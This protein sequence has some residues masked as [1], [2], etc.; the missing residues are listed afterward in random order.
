MNNI[1]KA[2]FLIALT[3]ASSA[4][5]ERTQ[6]INGGNTGTTSATVIIPPNDGTAHITDLVWDLDNTVTT[7]TI[8]IRPGKD[9]FSVTSATSGTGSVIWFDNSASSAAAASYLILETSTSTSLVRCT[10]VATTSVTVQETVAAMAVGNKVWTTRGTFRRNAPDQT[11]SSTLAP[12]NLYLPAKVPS[13]ITID[14]NTTA[15]KIYVG[16]ERSRD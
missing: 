3:F 4:F 9:E 5:A 14:G 6:V 2:L 10:A 16:G 1:Y 8:D 7:G 13:A 12:V 11:T 15:C